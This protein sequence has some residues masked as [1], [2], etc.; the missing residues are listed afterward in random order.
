MCHQMAVKKKTIQVDVGPPV[1][2]PMEEVNI[3]RKHFAIEI[4]GLF[5]VFET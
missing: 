2:K 3:L 1:I 5:V 4:L